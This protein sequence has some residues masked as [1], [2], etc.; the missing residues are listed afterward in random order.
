MA[1][2]SSLVAF[3][4]FTRHDMQGDRPIDDGR[5]TRRCI[6]FRPFIAFLAWETGARVCKAGVPEASMIRSVQAERLRG[7][8]GVA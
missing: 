6:Y 4:A 7:A 8:T 1:V 2:A 3:P 5:T